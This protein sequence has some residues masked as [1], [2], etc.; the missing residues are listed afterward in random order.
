MYA[1]DV[2]F[3]LS[4]NVGSIRD[5]VERLNYDLNRVFNWAKANGL[6]LNPT[7][8]KCLI[9]HR[10]KYF[11]PH[12]PD[13]IINGQKVDVVTRAKNLGVIFN[14][15][16]S[17]TDHVNSAAGQTYARLRALWFS[18][19]YTPLNIRILLAKT[20]LV[21]GL[22]YGCELFANCDSGSLR[23]LNVAF[24]SI[25]RYVY[26][27]NRRQRVAH[28][29]NSLYGFSFQTLLN[30]KALIFLQK[31]IVKRTPHNLYYKL[32]F[33]RSSRGRKIIPFRR[34]C[35]VSEWHFF[36]STIR[37]WNTLPSNIQSISNPFIFQ[38]RIL[39]LYR[40]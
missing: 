39:Q 15:S 21:P 9:I 1:D 11:H 30:S 3:F 37:L 36:I 25:I 16:L 14:S 33:A 38:K 35:L 31:L 22:I 20:L 5:T 6:L 32:R 2:Q 27:L 34:R 23:R 29:A 18:H 4:G 19:S 28:L 26:G 10:N 12:A 24:N 8:S 17:W 13:I 7:K 40:D